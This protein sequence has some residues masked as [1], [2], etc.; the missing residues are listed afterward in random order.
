MT[1]RFIQSSDNKYVQY[2]LMAQDFTTDVSQWQGVDDEP[3][4]ASENLVKSGGVAILT[5]GK[6]RY[7]IIGTGVYTILAFPFIAKSGTVVKIKHNLN[8]RLGIYPHNSNGVISGEIITLTNNEEV[9][10]TATEDIIGFAFWRAQAEDG[11]F[12]TFRINGSIN[13]AIDN[14]Q[15]AIGG[16][17]SKIGNVPVGNSLQSEIETEATRALSSENAIKARAG[18]QKTFDVIGQGG[19]SYSPFV[20]P[21]KH[22]S[23]VAIKHNLDSKLTVYPKNS[24][25]VISGISITLN[26]N[27]E[28][29]YYATEDIVAFTFYRSQVA[30]DDITF[31]LIYG[32]IN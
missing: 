23:V 9:E 8:T 32:D 6:K 14:I 29:L 3:V 26:S 28:V 4:A 22:G 12:I 18:E 15:N 31:T 20:F 10:Y 30:E 17:N 16:I 13:D 27:S 21:V 1:I 7:N 19:D 2:R 11:D 25:G 5:G 24:E